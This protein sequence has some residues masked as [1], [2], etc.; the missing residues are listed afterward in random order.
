MPNKSARLKGIH[1]II[2]VH[3]IDLNVSILQF[4][5]ESVDMMLSQSCMLAQLDPSIIQRKISNILIVAGDKYGS[6]WFGIKKQRIRYCII[7][8]SEQF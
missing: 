2:N 3:I 6:I 5:I 7:S 1:G 8:L 4:R